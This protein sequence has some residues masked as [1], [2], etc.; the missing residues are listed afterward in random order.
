MAIF[1]RL[2]LVAVMAG[3]STG[4]LT[5]AAHQ[6]LTVPLILQAE[7][8]EARAMDAHHGH[9]H[10][11]AWQPAE[12]WERTL[13][14]AFSDVM[15][16][17]G[18]ALLLGALWIWRGVPRGLPQA[19]AWGLAAYASFV[20]APSLGLPAALP[21]TDVGPLAARQIWWLSSAVATA[22]GLAVLVF[23]RVLA[24]RI[25]AVVLLASPHLI[26]APQAIAAASVLPAG[27]HGDF[28]RA[29]LAVGLLFW[30]MLAASTAYFFRREARRA[31]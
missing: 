12:G 8:Y 25:A 22:G 30:L 21:G 14:T 31:A 4:L 23:A 17:I 7:V 16:A 6:A 10:A 3:L 28:V 15:T 9:H 27:L 29:V 5:T 18:F 24:W 13:F 2:L 26:G 1:Q 19:L 20:L 11:P